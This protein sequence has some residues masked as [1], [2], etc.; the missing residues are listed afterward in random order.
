MNKFNNEEIARLLRRV[1]AAYI[2]KNFNRFRIIAYDKA[3]DSIEKSN[4]EVRDL[5]EQN[6]LSDLPGIGST[7]AAHLDDLFK[8]GKVK[9]FEQAFANL[10]Q[11]MFPLL[12]VP[13]FGPKK[14]YLLSD[15]FRL[16][17][18]DTAINK[19]LA[20]AKSGKIAP[21]EGFGAKSEQ[22]IIAALE[23]FIKGQTK[24]KRMPL[25]YA[26]NAARLVIEYLKS[27][28]ATE[29]AYLLG[30]LRRGVSTIGD[31]DIGVATKKEQEVINFF[32]K[33]P[34][35][36]KKIEQGE[37]GASILLITGQQIDIRVQ[38]P[39]S[40]GAMLQYFTGSKAH[41]IRLRELAVKKGL[42]L[43][44]Y[45]IKNIKTGKLKK[46][47]SEEGI[48]AALNLPFIPPELRE[49]WGEIYAAEAQKLPE[50]IAR[51]QIKGEVHVHSDYDLKPSHDLG[52]SSVEELLQTAQK[53]NYEYLGISDHN[54]KISGL[55]EN[56]IIS[57]MKKRKEHFEHILSSNKNIR[58]KLFIMLEVDILP[59]GNLAL[60]AQAFD[61]VD[62]VLVSIHS[63]FTQDRETM[64]QRILTGLSH[65][66]AKIFAHPSGRLIGKREGVNADWDKVF[67]FCRQK[68]KALEINSYP[69]R[70]DLADIMVKK[71][72]DSGNK[73]VIDTDSHHKEQM[74]LID[75]GITVARRGWAEKKDILNTL[76]YNEFAEWLKN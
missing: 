70:L 44:E 4:I 52:A 26:Y 33:Y 25:P 3:A 41:N 34:K 38:R 54:P 10:P 9:H 20:I 76:P 64:T 68:N 2:I 65:P 35:S 32:L 72:V 7:I 18:S 39:E 23:G 6:R 50:L 55:S 5:W 11:G 43:S 12:D 62:A 13:G 71:A 74:T 67:D 1:S 66:K 53:L 17:D 15:K 46:Y 14:A 24:K 58:V 16:N 31:I 40:F 21:L 48:Y 63:S 28:R 8:N 73:L 22:D 47:A 59:D 61:Y 75:Y 69:D 36:V 57:I 56:Q 37:S 49:D 42:S 60:P 29:N 19:L 45:G 27:N 30:S 51:E